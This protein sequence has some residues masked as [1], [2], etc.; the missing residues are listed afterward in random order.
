MIKDIELIQTDTGGYDWNFTVDD[1]VIARN[2]NQI[3]SAV[4]QAVMLKPYELE[5]E[6]YVTMGNTAHNY[7]LDKPTSHVQ[8]LIQEGIKSAVEEIA[9]ITDAEIE[10]SSND[11]NTSINIIVMKDDGEE[12]AID[13]ISI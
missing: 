1:L 4:I 12:V 6:E 9:G 5:N 8:D 11:G 13:G 2:N 7:V 3:R 10:L